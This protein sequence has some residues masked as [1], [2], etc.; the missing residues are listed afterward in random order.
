MFRRI[1]IQAH[2]VPHLL[3]QPRIG[4]QLACFSAVRLQPK[5][6]PDTDHCALTQTYILRKRPGTPLGGRN[7]LT[8]Q[9]S[10]DGLLH[11]GVRDAAR[12]AG[13]RI[14]RSSLHPV[15]PVPLSPL[16]C[17]GTSDTQLPGD[18]PIAH[19]FGGTQHNLRPN[20]HPLGCPGPPSQQSQL[21]P[22]SRLHGPWLLWSPRSHLASGLPKPRISEAGYF[23]MNF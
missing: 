9:R 23:A 1:Q 20:G 17:S 12:C 2:D 6:S 10:C 14:V 13:S 4:R 7:R 11:P 8:F 5:A 3:H 15:Q 19:T 16:P 18:F 22:V 21:L